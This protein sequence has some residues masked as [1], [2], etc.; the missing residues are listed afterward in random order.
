[1]SQ[2]ISRDD[3]HVVSAFD[4]GGRPNGEPI[5][6]AEA[7]AQPLIIPTK[8]NGIRAVIDRYARQDGLVVSPAFEVDSVEIIKRLLPIN[9]GPTILPKFSVVQE[10]ASG[11]FKNNP[12]IKPN[13]EYK[14][15]ITFPV[16]RPLTR[17]AAAV[18]DILRSIA[19]KAL[20]S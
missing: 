13:L 8:A 15:D 9:I 2:E 16:D 10:L 5:T 11:A 4:A 7:I 12:I 19:A 18:A 14:V 3:L 1:M 17:N 20:G 6:F